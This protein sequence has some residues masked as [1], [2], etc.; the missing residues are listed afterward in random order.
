VPTGGTSAHAFTLV[1]DDEPEAFAAQV[2]ALGPGTTLLVDT[3][4]I[5][6]GITHA[7]AAAGPGLGAVRIDSGDLAGE[8]RRARALLD[9]LGAAGTRIVISGD[10]DEWRIAELADAP[11]DRMLVGTQLVVGSGAPT[12]GLVYKLVAVADRPGADAPLRPVAKRSLGKATRG[13]AKVAYRR[14][15]EDGRAQVELVGNPERVEAGLGTDRLRPLQVVLVAGGVVDPAGFDL[16]AARRH[17]RVGLAELG[18][19]ATALEDGPPA[20]AVVELDGDG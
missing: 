10:L 19:D 1:H 6:T 4:D 16:E 13:G 20:L 7:V 5:A 15:D 9:E 11:V 12:A 14:L 3:F 18:P 2:A 17:H 8:A